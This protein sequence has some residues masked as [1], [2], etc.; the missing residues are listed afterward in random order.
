MVV[1]PDPAPASSLVLEGLAAVN[2]MV[3][4]RKHLIK[5]EVGHQEVSDPSSSVSPP[6]RSSP[7]S[8]LPA[9][10]CIHTTTHMATTTAV[11]VA[12]KPT[13]VA[14]SCTQSS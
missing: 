6:S 10:T 1:R 4:D 12:T 14:R 13:L 2:F 9:H 3:E 5:L 7:V 11:L 8:G